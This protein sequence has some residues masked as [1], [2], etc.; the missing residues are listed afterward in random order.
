VPEHMTEVEL[1]TTFQDVAIVDEVTIIKDKAS[2]W[3]RS[4]DQD[5]GS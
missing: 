3:C 5:L 2:L 4:L 1:L